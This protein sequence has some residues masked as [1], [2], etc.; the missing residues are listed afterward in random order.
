MKKRYYGIIS[1]TMGAMLLLT[2][3]SNKVDLSSAI[4]NTQ[5]IK[6]YAYD[7]NLSVSETNPTVDTT[8]PTSALFQDGKISLDFNGKVKDTGDR[9]K[10]SS[11]V[12]VSSSGVSFEDPIYI[13]S[14]KKG[15][16]FNLFVGVPGI[17]K[18]QLGDMFANVSNLYLG[19]SDLGQFIKDT[20]GEEAYK[21]FQKALEGSSDNTVSTQAGLDMLKVFNDHVKENKNKISEFKAIDKLSTSSNGI[22]TITFTKD[23]IKAL[24]SDYLSNEKYFKN[25]QEAMKKSSEIS[26]ASGQ[27]TTET[28]AIKDLDAKEMINNINT[29]LDDYNEL[30]VVTKFTIKDKLIT[31][32]NVK[33]TVSTSDNTVTVNLDN[34]ISDIDKVDD[35]QMPDKKADSTLNVLELYKGLMSMQS[36][37]NV[38]EPTTTIDGQ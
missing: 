37:L 24:A 20:Q 1:A 33:T 16:D 9:V 15:F 31:E 25:F 13:D 12:K 26:A 30:K 3:C 4:A 32:T 36:Q 22:Y 10:L 6:S 7:L 28:D 18:S 17:F 19:S 38:T 8:N 27:G 34:K 23:D 11:N 35:I 2:G 29:A 21:E 5:N 14:A